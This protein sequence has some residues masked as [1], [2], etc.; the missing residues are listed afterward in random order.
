MSPDSPTGDALE[1]LRSRAVAVLSAHFVHDHL[2]IEELETRLDR[3][4]R[5]TS[6]A[7]LDLLTEN[8]PSLPPAEA[9]RLGVYRVPRLDHVPERRRVLN[10][11]G[12][13]L[14]TGGWVVPHHL[15]VVKLL[16]DVKLDLREARFGPEPSELV[17]HQGLGDLKLIV[18]PGLRLEIDIVSVLGDRK[19]AEEE[20]ASGAD[21]DA[22]VFRISGTQIIGDIE[23]IRR[24]PGEPERRKRD[25]KR[26]LLGGG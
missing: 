18:P 24:L 23:V 4:A 11:L 25:R 20:V 2:D 5:A 17:L 10:L 21:P 9:G 13:F 8:L 14:R 1:G 16:G 26:R 6:R 3:A 12:D 19:E 7:E 15:L 22:P